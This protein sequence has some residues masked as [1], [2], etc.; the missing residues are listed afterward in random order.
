[1]IGH[2]AHKKL[3]LQIFKYITMT[4]LTL[5]SDHAMATGMNI[6]ANELPISLDETL[7]FSNFLKECKMSTGNLFDFPIHTNSNETKDHLLDKERH[8][9][10]CSIYHAIILQYNLPAEFIRLYRDVSLDEEI[11]WRQWTFMTL[12]DIERLSNGHTQKHFVAIASTY[13]GMGWVILLCWDKNLKKYFLHTDG[14]ENDY[15]R[16]DH[17][18]YFRTKVDTPTGFQLNKDTSKVLTFEEFLKFDPSN[19]SS[20]AYKMNR[21][22][23]NDYTYSD[24]ED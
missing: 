16:R 13:M 3:N 14:G 23:V 12:N 19:Y 2:M 18:T 7:S 24:D 6:D 1:M 10:G 21:S 4:L 11:I 15:T 9:N 22:L 17:D 20:H 5:V 8:T